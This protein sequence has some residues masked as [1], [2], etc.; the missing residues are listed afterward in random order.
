MIAEE[1]FRDLIQEVRAGNPAAA[2]ELV[3]LYEP[4]IR[5]LIRVRL[6]DP[7]LRRLVDS[8]DICQSVLAAFFVRVAAGQFDLE[9]PKQLV[10]L[11]LTMARNKLLDHARRPIARTT[12]SADSDVLQTTADATDSPSEI[13]AGAELVARASALLTDDERAIFDMRKE[14]MGWAEIAAALGTSS[15]AARK[16]YHRAVD[17]ACEQLGLGAPVDA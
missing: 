17:R 12:R 16:R 14:G 4:E 9:H 8:V 2:T 11:L 15:E 5:R 13:V 7:N 3:R 6:T 10:G 1:S